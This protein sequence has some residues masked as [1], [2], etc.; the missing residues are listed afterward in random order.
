MGLSQSLFDGFRWFYP[1][2]DIICPICS[3]KTVIVEKLH[4]QFPKEN[5]HYVCI[6][7]RKALFKRYP[8]PKCPICLRPCLPVLI[9]SYFRCNLCKKMK[10]EL[11]ITKHPHFSQH[12][13]H[14]FCRV[15][16]NKQKKCPICKN[17]LDDVV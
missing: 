4:K 13:E 11:G 10:T 12:D 17:F 14:R 8:N 7:C 3:R 2:K 1:H 16:I 5:P 9:T 15:C 6:P